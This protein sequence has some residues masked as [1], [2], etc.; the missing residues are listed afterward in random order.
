MSKLVIKNVSEITFT[1]RKPTIIHL[2][3]KQWADARKDLKPGNR[4]PRNGT[5]IVIVPG[6]NGSVYAIPYC[7]ES[8]LN[9]EHIIR[10]KYDSGTQSLSYITHL[11][12]DEGSPT[13]SDTGRKRRKRRHCII[14]ITSGKSTKF[15]C[16]SVSCRGG[17]KLHSKEF[18]VAGGK[19]IYFVFCTCG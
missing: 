12:V 4:L 7:N 19:T 15:K 14:S 11:H 18:K 8:G 6:A 17:C 13:V 10:P 5:A 9:P 1:P 2:N 3:E 16:L